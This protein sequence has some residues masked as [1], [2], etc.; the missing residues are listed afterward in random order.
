MPLHLGKMYR[1]PT[2]ANLFAPLYAKEG[3]R[4]LCD[5]CGSLIC[6]V[7]EP[8]S[9]MEMRRWWSGYGSPHAYGR[10]I[11]SRCQGHFM[12]AGCL[13]FGDELPP[14]PSHIQCTG[15]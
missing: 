2:A 10:C 13:Y 14:D 5:T 3:E 4:V 6:E 15:V 1:S 12:V 8:V 11:Y 7:E 9:Y